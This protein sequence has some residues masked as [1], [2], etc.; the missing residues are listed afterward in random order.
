MNFRDFFFADN[1]IVSKI[2]MTWIFQASKFKPTTKTS[3]GARGLLIWMDSAIICIHFQ[4][5]PLPVSL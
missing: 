1:C 4:S 2:L 5:S 3:E